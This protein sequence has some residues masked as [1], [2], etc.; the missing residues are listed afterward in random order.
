MET[1]TEVWE[2]IE[3]MYASQSRARV[4]NTCMALATTSKGAS[5][6]T[7]YFM[8]M[9]GLADEMASTRKKLEDEELVSYILVGLDIEFN[10]LMSAIVA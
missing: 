6:A 2:A 9:N 1:A 7:E 8:K 10:P 3:V 4:I 5:T